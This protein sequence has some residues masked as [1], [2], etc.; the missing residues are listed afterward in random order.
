MS[1]TRLPWAVVYH[2]EDGQ[3]RI[4]AGDGLIATIA[5][6]PDSDEQQANATLLCESPIL[7]AAAKSVLKAYGLFNRGSHTSPTVIE[8]LDFAVAKAEGR[9]PIQLR[10]DAASG[11]V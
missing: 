7:L 11:G 2:Q 8:Q 4:Y 6:R 10:D 9:A 5:P 3:H 1:H